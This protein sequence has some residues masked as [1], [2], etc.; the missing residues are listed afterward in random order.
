MFD[1]IY[2]TTDSSEK[3]SQP[4]FV[5]LANFYGVNNPTMADLK[6]PV[7]CHWMG[8]W[9]EKHSSVVYYIHHADAPDT[10]NIKGVDKRWLESNKIWVFI[11]FILI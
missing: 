5:V 3:K 11:A 4:R 6:L 8:S 2:L 9:E 1:D 7:R 10:N